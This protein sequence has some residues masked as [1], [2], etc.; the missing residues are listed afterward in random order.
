MT[1]RPRSTSATRDHKLEFELR[2]TSLTSTPVACR[3]ASRKEMG[4]SRPRSL[5]GVSRCHNPAVL[6]QH[7]RTQPSHLQLSFRHLHTAKITAITSGFR[8]FRRCGPEWGSVICATVGSDAHDR[9]CSFFCLG[10]VEW[11]KIFRTA[12]FEAGSTQRD[13]PPREQSKNTKNDDGGRRD[14]AQYVFLAQ[15]VFLTTYPVVQAG[16][17]TRTRESTR[18]PVAVGCG[19]CCLHPRTQW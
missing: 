10:F 11:Q 17:V 18:D 4:S 7:N 9:L 5:L 16:S 15:N 19:C 2:T 6:V 1:A 13:S 14:G 12:R 3:S 8:V